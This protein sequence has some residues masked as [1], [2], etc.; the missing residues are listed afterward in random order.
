MSIKSADSKINNLDDQVGQ[1]HFT[2]EVV[3]EIVQPKLAGVS[4][5]FQVAELRKGLLRDTKIFRLLLN[6]GKTE[7]ADD[8]FVNSSEIFLEQKIE[9]SFPCTHHFLEQHWQPSDYEFIVSEGDCVCEMDKDS[10]VLM[11]RGMLRFGCPLGYSLGAIKNL[12]KYTP[13]QVSSMQV[14]ASCQPDDESQDPI[15]H[16]ADYGIINLRDAIKGIS[17]YPKICPGEVSSSDWPPEETR[18]IA[19]G[20]QK[21]AAIIETSEIEKSRPFVCNECNGYSK[22]CEAFI[23]DFI[24]PSRMKGLA[25]FLCPGCSW[26]TEWARNCCMITCKR[27]EPFGCFSGTKTCAYCVDG[28]TGL[29]HD[30][31][32]CSAK[33]VECTANKLPLHPLRLCHCTDNS[34]SSKCEK[35]LRDQRAKGSKNGYFET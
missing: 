6:G 32:L 21:Y 30:L 13:Q 25:I 33:V 14:Q 24:N 23:T 1:H 19:N 16:V 34:S 29:S 35:E 11:Q 3:F 8:E 4:P 10:H 28:M 31:A 27:K 22:P 2:Q 17:S 18:S 5:G 20:L 15:R 26:A 9:N 7:L 12:M